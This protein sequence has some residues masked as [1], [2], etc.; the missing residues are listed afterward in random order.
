MNNTPLGLIQAYGEGY[1]TRKDGTIQHFTFST[2]G[3]VD[4]TDT[5]DHDAG[6]DCGRSGHTGR[7]ERDA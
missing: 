2:E 4:G 1:I 7:D 6:R 3:N 5:S